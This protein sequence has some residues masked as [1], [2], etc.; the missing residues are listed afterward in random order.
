MC[1]RGKVHV[2][3]THTHNA[4]EYASMSWSG[5]VCVSMCFYK[6]AA[7][8]RHKPACRSDKPRNVVMTGRPWSLLSWWRQR[9]AERSPPNVLFQSAWVK[10]VRF[11]RRRQNQTGKHSEK[12]N[13]LKSDAAMPRRRSKSGLK[14]SLD[15]AAPTRKLKILHGTGFI[16][17]IVLYFVIILI[18][19]E[20]KW[21]ERGR[22]SMK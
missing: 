8:C 13:L 5:T 1:E 2:L 20:E 18:M 4:D 11:R 12:E 15:E 9:E 22:R 21:L 19:G 7:P 17:D 6:V 14:S 3:H 10:I 16:F